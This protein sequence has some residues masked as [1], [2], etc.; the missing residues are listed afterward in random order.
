VA[1][2]EIELYNQSM[3]SILSLESHLTLIILNTLLARYF[4]IIHFYSPIDSIVKEIL[5]KVI[6]DAITKYILDRLEGILADKL[7]AN[8]SQRDAAFETTYYLL[9]GWTISH[10]RNYAQTYSENRFIQNESLDQVKVLYNILDPPKDFLQYV[11][12]KEAKNDPK[13]DRLVRVLEASKD[14]L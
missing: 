6:M 5:R 10:F 14:T 3:A 9:S 4:K 2:Q 7:Y 13:I 11:L 1:G 12:G 8:K